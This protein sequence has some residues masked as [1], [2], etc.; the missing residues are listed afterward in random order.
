MYERFYNLAMPPFENTPDPRFFFQSE[1]HREALAVIEY[2]I[3][4]G[5]G[6]VLITGDIGSGKTTVTRTLCDRLANHARVVTITHGHE[7][8]DSV[9]RQVLRELG[10]RIGRRD[11]H[12]R[13]IERLRALLAKQGR[14]RR[15]LVLVAD[16][17]QALTDAALEELRLTSS[18][19]TATRKCVQVALIGQPELR[20]RLAE[21]RFEALRQRLA[22][23]R[24]LRPLGRDETI[25]YINHRLNVAAGDTASPGAAF[26]L[27]AYNRIHQTSR[28][29]PR[30]INVV[31]DNCLLMGMVRE[32]RTIGA[33]L[34]DKA[35][36]DMMPT[37]D[38]A[39]AQPDQPRLA[40]T[41]T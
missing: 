2:T 19:D 3:R 7:A 10:A 6:F 35:A 25:A 13:L 20:K 30:L 5:K 17:A 40:L 29:I 41:G 36:Q 15:P 37:L 32:L 12:A 24:Q 11:D 21:P 4:L 28:G 33:D 9:M 27:A 16:E 23:A 8:G 34:V 18:F 22:M 38:E 14:D 31:C 1:E 39:K 26:T